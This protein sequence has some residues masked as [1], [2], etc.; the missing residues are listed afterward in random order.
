MNAKTSEIKRSFRSCFSLF[1]GMLALCIAPP[2][3]NGEEQGASEDADVQRIASAYYAKKYG[4]DL[5]EAERRLAI[6]DRAA[7]I[8]DDLPRSSATNT[9]AFGT[10][11]RTPANS[12]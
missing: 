12:R 1:A 4:V 3:A 7:G 9:Q 8:E 11:K 6:Q 2:F 10:T 5:R